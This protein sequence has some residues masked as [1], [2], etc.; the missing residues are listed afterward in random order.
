MAQDRISMP[1]SQG[2]LIRYFEDYRSK[3]SLKPGHV[4]VLVVVV[5]ILVIILHIYGGRLLGI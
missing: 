1:S 4:I 3:I 5:M 2:G